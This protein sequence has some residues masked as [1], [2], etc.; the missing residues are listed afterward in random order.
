M[1]VSDLTNEVV[2]KMVTRWINE[3]HASSP[4]DT[5]YTIL[6]DTTINSKYSIYHNVIPEEGMTVPKI[7][8]FGLGINGFYN[9]DDGNMSAP[10]HP[11]ADELDLYEPI[12]IRCVPVANDLSSTERANYRMR[13]EKIFNGERYYCYYLKKITLIDNEVQLT[14]TNPVNKTEEPFE[15]NPSKLIPTPVIPTTSGE[16]EGIISEVNASLRLGLNWVGSEVLEAIN[17]IYGGDM[18]RA[19]ISE[20]G[21][22]SGIDYNVT[23]YNNVNAEITYTESI[24]TQLAYKICNIGSVITSDKYDGSRILV[25]SN[26]NNLSL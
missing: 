16:V 10:Y 14:R 25:L 8:Y 15:L 9:V 23:G 4:A 20:I 24:Y 22:Y 26:G 19:K 17:V 7:M 21:I 5:E 1:A 13:V 12:P 6:P 11:A 18:R 3:I 2:V